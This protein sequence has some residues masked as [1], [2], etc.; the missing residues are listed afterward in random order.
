MDLIYTNAKRIDQG[1][2]PKY[3]LDL[4]YGADENENDFELTVGK[5]EKALEKKAIIYIEGTEY[6][7]MVG[8]TRSS[9]TENVVTYIGRTWHG[10]LNSKVIEPYD[11]ESYFVV[12]GEAND[13]LSLLIL[14]LGLSELFSVEE[15]QKTEYT[16]TLN[17]DDYIHSRWHGSLDAGSDKPYYPADEIGDQCCT[18]KFKTKFVPKITYSYFT[19]A[20]EYVFWKNGSFVKK[21]AYSEISKEWS[22]NFDFD[23]VAINFSWGWD[24]VGSETIVTLELVKVLSE[25]NISKY[26]F[27]RYCKGYDGIR[28]MLAKNGAKLKISW[29]DRSVCLSAEPIVDYTESPVDGD[30]AQMTVEQHETKVNHLIC[31]GRGELSAR[32][33]IH[34]YVDQFGRIGEVQHFR[35][36]EEVTDVYDNN[37]VESLEELKDGGIARLTELRNIDKVEMG[38]TESE[39]PTYD[40]G[41][42]VSATDVYSGISA[43]S[44][45][46]QKIVRINNGV[47]STEYKTGG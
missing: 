9:S 28:A 27:H 15:R 42:I 33:V 14:R 4:S 10:I 11:G 40:I 16:Y 32:E 30:I 31:L 12:S 46:S 43:A 38:L 39:N 21:I 13:I 2:L 44:A 6:G 23:E 35:N 41:D 37:S 7:G 22:V 47:I 26:Q 18:K 36:L 24:Y 8:G 3:T 5:S 45:V 29:K 19:D 34:L 1:V 20:I 17:T 25:I